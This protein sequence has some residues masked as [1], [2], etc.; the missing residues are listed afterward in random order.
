[1]SDEVG[2]MDV[3]MNYKDNGFRAGLAQAK[4]WLME[5]K[6]SSKSVKVE[7]TRLGAAALATGVYIA[8]L[9]KRIMNMMT[10]TLADSPFLIGAMTRI[11]T[12]FQLLG[13]E[14]TKVLKPIF[15]WL[16]DKL[17]DLYDW[18]TDLNPRV[19]K[20][21]SWITILG[22]VAAS[23]ILGIGGIALTLKGLGFAGLLTAI[24]SFVGWV[25]GIGTAFLASEA[26]V[27]AMGVSLGIVAGFIA[28]MALDELGILD[29][30]SDLGAGFR[31]ALDNG[32]L[33]A[34]ALNLIM[35]PLS[36]IG[37]LI[38]VMVTDKTMEDFWKDMDKVADSA[39]NMADALKGAFGFDKPANFSMSAVDGYAVGTMAVP[40]TGMYKLHAGETVN[41]AGVSRGSSGGSTNIVVDFGNAVINLASGIDLENLADTISNRIAE[42]QAWEAF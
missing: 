16:A 26:F 11:K 15:D 32:N 28:V 6:Q 10:N 27:A 35:T 9:G 38:L 29:W 22:T 36:V 14:I 39:R 33:L 5:T 23:A 1:M 24:E 4:A 2:S 42:K 12:T 13:W 21:V 7:M 18:F 8:K 20:F 30:I 37:D 41:P 31:D 34:D 19:Q 3:V 40:S 25:V 17:G